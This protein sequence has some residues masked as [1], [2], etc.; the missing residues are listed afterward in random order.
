MSCFLRQRTETEMTRS[1]AF[2]AAAAVPAGG[3]LRLI[4]GRRTGA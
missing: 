1:F 3:T 4:A 2:A